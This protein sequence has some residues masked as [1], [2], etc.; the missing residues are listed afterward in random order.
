MEVSMELDTQTIGKRIKERRKTLGL[1]QL[2]IKTKVGISSGNI[3]DI[4][5]GNRLPAATTLVQ[6]AQV[7]ECSIDYIL[8]G[9]S[10][11]SEIIAYSDIGESAQKLLNFFYT[12]SEEDQEELIMI[13]EM[14]SRKRKRTISSLSDT[15]NLTS[16][17]A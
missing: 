15:E 2:D 12:L 5:R 8:T 3:S 9:V 13:A 11:D 1:T 17:T 16:E 4:E 14:K 10:P 6:L 7:L